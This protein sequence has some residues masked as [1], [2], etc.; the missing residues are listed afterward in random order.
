VVIV[1]WPESLTYNDPWGWWS[2][3]SLHAECRKA[4]SPPQG[5]DHHGG[6]FNFDFNVNLSHEFFVNSLVRDIISLRW[7]V[8]SIMLFY[9]LNLHWWHN[10]CF[11]VTHCS[12]DCGFWSSITRFWFMKNTEWYIISAFITRKLVWLLSALILN[13]YIQHEHF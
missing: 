8:S 2:F 4:H 12:L 13:L 5:G 10:H 6:K 1:L 9:L 7:Y 3:R 11:F